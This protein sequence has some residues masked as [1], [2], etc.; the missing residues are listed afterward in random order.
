M[1]I[2]RELSLWYSHS[3]S[4]DAHLVFFLGLGRSTWALVFKLVVL[5]LMVR[6]VTSGSSVRMMGV[7]WIMTIGDIFMR[8][9]FVKMLMY[10][11]DRVC[12]GLF[13]DC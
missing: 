13:F 6:S 7:L 1:G 3:S 10:A 5:S 12:N 9:I 2:S 4:S 8:L 11:G